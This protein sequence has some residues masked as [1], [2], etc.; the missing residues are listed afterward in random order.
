M[1][2]DEE[3]EPT[4]RPIRL[5]NS[6]ALLKE[7]YAGRRLESPMGGFLELLGSQDQ[8]DGSGLLLFE[9]S[10]SSLRFE[11]PVPKGTRRD[12]EKV[13]EQAEASEELRCPRCEP[14]R[15]LHRNGAD[16]ACPCGASFGRAP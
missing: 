9:C 13:K 5:K 7:Y 16:L 10:T 12:R 8:E 11:L 6:K 14:R 2:R 3:A 15:P 1:W 4:A